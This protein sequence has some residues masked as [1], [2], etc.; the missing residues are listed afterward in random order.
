M[1]GTPRSRIQASSRAFPWKQAAIVAAVALVVRAL[2]WLPASRSLFM[3]TPV[4][5]ASFFD[6]WA[7]S[8]VEGREFQAQAFFKPP[9]AAWVLAALYRLGLGMHGVLVLQLG[10]GV[11]TSVITFAIA[12]LAFTP[13]VALAGAIAAAALPIL[14]F[15]E[16]QMVAEAWTTALAQGAVLLFLLG[17]QERAPRAVQKLAAAGLLLGLAALGRPN[18]LVVLPVLAA[19]LWWQ[20]SCG[21]ACRLD[22]AVVAP[23]GAGRRGLRPGDRTGHAAQPALRRVRADQR[24]PR[25]EPA[26]RAQ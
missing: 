26:D 19:W 7:R 12:R 21:S 11:V 6:I 15:F 2:F 17:T 13:R 1:A 20:G 8:L 3:Q 9:L 14:P 5:D 10:V 23:R 25:R 24:E 22:A 16:A 18:V 4:V